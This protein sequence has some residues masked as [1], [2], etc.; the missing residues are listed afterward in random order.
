MTAIAIADIESSPIVGDVV[1]GRPVNPLIFNLS[2]IPDPDTLGLSGSNLWQVSVFGSNSPTGEG[3]ELNPQQQ[4]LTGD[5]LDV[6]LEPGSPID[7][8]AVGVNYNM[9]GVDCASMGYICARLSKNPSA[10][11]DYTLDGT[12]DESVLVDCQPVDCRGETF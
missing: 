12:P 1:E 3:P 2:A 5:Q 7:F 8:G 10:S 9:L 11:I 6:D 4:V